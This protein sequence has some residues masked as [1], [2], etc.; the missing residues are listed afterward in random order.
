MAA[1]DK[2]N[3]TALAD[4]VLR[5]PNPGTRKIA[6]QGL[7]IYM[8]YERIAELVRYVSQRDSNAEVRETAANLLAA[9]IEKLAASD[10]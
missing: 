1:P 9:S 2:F 4:E 6:L 5:N 7:S 8:R 3:V 10:I